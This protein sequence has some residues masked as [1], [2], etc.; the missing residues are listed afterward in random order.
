MMENVSHTIISRSFRSS[1]PG[2]L[3]LSNH[4]NAFHDVK[5]IVIV[6]QKLLYRVAYI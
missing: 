6:A 5:A 4:T 3:R 1:E 2:T